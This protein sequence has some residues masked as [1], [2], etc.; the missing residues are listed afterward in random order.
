MN[1]KR[2]LVID[3]NHDIA[4]IVCATGESMKISCTMVSDVASLFAALTPEIS[5]VVMDLKMPEMSGAE[6]MVKLAAHGCKARL[7]LMSGVGPNALREAEQ[8]GRSLG[9][10]VLGSLAKP[11]R[12]AELRAMLGR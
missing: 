11:F 5:L 4:E 3:D 9:L 12:G 6:L 8:L 10:D 2:I 1:A 7:L